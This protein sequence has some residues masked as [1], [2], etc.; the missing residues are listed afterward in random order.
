MSDRQA[1]KNLCPLLKPDVKHRLPSLYMMAQLR[2]HELVAAHYWPCYKIMF[3]F[4]A[5]Q[6]DS[7]ISNVIC[8]KFL[9]KFFRLLNLREPP[10]EDTRFHFFFGRRNK[11]CYLF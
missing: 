10:G 3:W 2:A 6:L 7:K 4:H 1:L 9:F 8:L 11:E 5:S